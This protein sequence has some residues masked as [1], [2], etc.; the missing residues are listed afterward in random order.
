MTFIIFFLSVRNKFIPLQFCFVY[1]TTFLL[2]FIHFEQ[3][4]YFFDI[5]KSKFLS[6]FIFSDNIYI[7]TKTIRI[8]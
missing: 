6:F 3:F 2:Y 5:K 4:I 1:L 7:V 8:I